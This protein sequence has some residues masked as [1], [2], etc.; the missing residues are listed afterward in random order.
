MEFFETN[1]AF[2]PGWPGTHGIDQAGLKPEV[3]LFALS[4]TRVSDICYQVQLVNVMFF[5]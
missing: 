1:F 2:I 4:S 3:S 5:F